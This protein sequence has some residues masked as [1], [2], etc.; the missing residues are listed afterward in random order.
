MWVLHAD[1]FHDG[2]LE[3]L[4][5]MNRANDDNSM[6][7]CEYF[8]RYQGITGIKNPDIAYQ[9]NGTTGF[10]TFSMNPMDSPIGGELL[11]DTKKKTYYFLT[12]DPTHDSTNHGED[13][14]LGKDHPLKSIGGTI[15]IRANRV[16]QYGV[17]P[18]CWI[19]WVP[20]V[21]SR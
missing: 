11:Y 14:I 3:T 16:D 9:F 17:G 20:S 15:G 12:W 7:R 8:D 13:A 1:L 2:N 10:F 18:F 6:P 5:R 19:D 21:K 4:V